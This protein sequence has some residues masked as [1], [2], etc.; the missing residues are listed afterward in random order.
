MKLCEML[1]KVTSSRYHDQ[2]MRFVAPLSDHFG[3]N[4]FWYYK[5]THSGHYSYFGTHADWNEYCVNESLLIN[6]PVL[7]H[8]EIIQNKVT[9]MK[10]YEDSAYQNVLKEV[11]DKFNINFNINLLNKVEN[12]VEAFGFATRFND[13]KADERLLNQLPM[14]TH[15]IKIFRANN[16]KI[17]ELLEDHQ[18]DLSSELGP[19]FFERPKE[20]SFP[21]D[22]EQFLEKIG[23]GFFSSLTD[24][25]MEILKYLAHGFPAPYIAQ[26]VHLSRRTVEAYIGIIKEKLGCVSKTELIQKAHDIISINFY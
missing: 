20:L 23:C 25:E 14:L 10:A 18:I 12:G 9:L 13:A 11:W 6:F 22:Q 15:F 26:Q 21:F 24:R 1:R 2:M 16:N 8:P 5:I 19:V 3:V 7:R 4:H 17:F